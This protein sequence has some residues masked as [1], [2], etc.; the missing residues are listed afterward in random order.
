[1]PTVRWG[2]SRQVGRVFGVFGRHVLAGG[3]SGRYGLAGGIS[4]R[5]GLAGGISVAIVSGARDCGRHE[6]AAA[7]RVATACVAAVRADDAS[8]YHAEIASWRS[9]AWADPHVSP[10]GQ[11]CSGGA[12]HLCDQ[13]C[14]GTVQ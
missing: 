13:S 11:T 3:I 7:V 10:P 9:V 5:H 6:E 4:G 1:M 12:R 2:Q 14:G 8:R